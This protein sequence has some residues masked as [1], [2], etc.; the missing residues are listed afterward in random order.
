MKWPAFGDC[1]IKWKGE[2]Q[3]F[4][5]ATFFRAISSPWQSSPR[6][7]RPRADS[8]CRCKNTNLGS[9]L[10]CLIGTGFCFPCRLTRE[11]AKTDFLHPS[12]LKES[13]GT[14]FPWN[15]CEKCFCLCPIARF[16]CLGFS[17]MRSHLV[18]SP[19]KKPSFRLFLVLVLGPW[20]RLREK[21][22]VVN[23]FHIVRFRRNFLS[24][25]RPN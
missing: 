18:C 23:S 17:E 8:P 7:R 20:R 6:D 9:V 2:G 21:I 10:S 22:S 15:M 19:G 11:R 13:E 24:P 14:G 12:N 25:S 3:D 4:R 5:S 1:L 16:Y